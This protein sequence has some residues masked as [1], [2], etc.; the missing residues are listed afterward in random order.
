MI[1]TINKKMLWVLINKIHIILI[2]NHRLV[3]DLVHIVF[4][5]LYEF[6]FQ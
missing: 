4:L 3:K 5:L 6:K 2:S 1:Q